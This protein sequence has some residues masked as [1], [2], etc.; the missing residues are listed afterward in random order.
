MRYR[1]L[2]V[3]KCV[4]GIKIMLVSPCNVYPVS[5]DFLFLC[6]V[7]GTDLILF[8]CWVMKLG[9]D[10]VFWRVFFSRVNGSVFQIGVNLCLNFVLIFLFLEKSCWKRIL[11]KDRDF[12]SFSRSSFHNLEIQGFESF[13]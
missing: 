6:L 2:C 4:V 8:R 11:F 13:C 9:L 5:S 3:I 12:T 1:V 10:P 7:L